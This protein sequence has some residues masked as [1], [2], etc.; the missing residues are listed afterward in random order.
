VDRLTETHPYEIRAALAFLEDVP[1]RP[2]AAAAAHRLGTLVRDRGLVVL[3][4]AR[5]ADAPVPPGYAPGEHH[6]A[7]D[8]AATPGALARGWFT[9]AELERSLDHLASLQCDDGGW[10][11]GAYVRAPGTAAESRPAITLRALLTLRAHGRQPG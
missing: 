7:Y 2:R 9:D 5:A 3:D 10:P 4:P 6:F 11:A 8:Y 1:D